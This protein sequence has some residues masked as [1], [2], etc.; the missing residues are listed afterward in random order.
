MDLS[1]E[2]ILSYRI[3]SIYWKPGE[4]PVGAK[5]KNLFSV[6]G[7]LERQQG[8]TCSPRGGTVPMERES[9][10]L[11]EVTVSLKGSV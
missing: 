6:F 2:S 4:I 8:Q 11:M 1:E 3:G 5:L 9:R 10:Q 7:E